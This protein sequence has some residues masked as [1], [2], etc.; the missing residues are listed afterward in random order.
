VIVLPVVTDNTTKA[1]IGVAGAPLTP[2]VDYT[3][4]LAQDAVVGSS[5]LEI[6]PLHP[7]SPSTCIANGQ[8]QGANC[9][10]G[11]GYLVFLTSGIKDASGHAA[12]ADK[13]HSAIK[14]ALAGGATCPSITDPTLNAVCQLTGA[15]LQIAHLVIPTL[16]RPASC[17]PSASPP[18]PP[19]TRSA[20]SRR[21]RNRTRWPCIR[22]ASTP[23]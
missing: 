12:V 21:P 4:G 6:T 20:E 15:H 23:R 10:T 5:I 17:C 7:L 11:T 13:D 3:V 9:K 19:W 22:P 14:T 16:I 8:F 18:S 2:G 1:T